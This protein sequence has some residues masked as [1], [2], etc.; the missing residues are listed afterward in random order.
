MAHTVFMRQHNR[1]A[2]ELGH[3]NG[4]WDDER[5][6]QEARRI[7]VAQMQHLTYNEWLPIIIGNLITQIIGWI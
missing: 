1:L 6:F 2:A 4:H 5:L 7:L 3:V